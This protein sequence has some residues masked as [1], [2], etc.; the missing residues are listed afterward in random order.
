MKLIYKKSDRII[1]GLGFAEIAQD[2]LYLADPSAYEII[3]VAMD[4]IP[5][6][7]AFWLPR[8]IGPGQVRQWIYNTSGEV[9]IFE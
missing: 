4:F 3:D 9:A 8:I 5:P 2:A 7:H 6:D 1:L